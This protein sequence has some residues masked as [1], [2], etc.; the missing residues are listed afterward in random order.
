MATQPERDH[1]SAQMAVPPVQNSATLQ[2]QSIDLPEEVRALLLTMRAQAKSQ[3]AVASWVSRIRASDR[4]GRAPQATR[5]ALAEIVAITSAWLAGMLAAFRPTLLSGLARIQTDFGDTRLANYI[6]EHGYRWLI[7]APGH[8]RFWSP[9]VFFPAPNTA[10][11]S[12]VLFTVAPVYWFWRALGAAPDTAFQLWMLTMATLNVVAA[13]LLLRRALHCS[14]VASAVGAFVFAFAGVR[15]AQLQHPQLLPQFYTI[16]AVYALVRLFERHSDTSHAFG[17]LAVFSASIVAQLYAEFYYGW[18][19]CFVIAICALWA[20]LIPQSRAALLAL[21]RRQWLP[22]TLGVAAGA[23]LLAPLAMH[24]LSAA[25]VLGPRGFSTAAAMVPRPLSWID[26]GPDNW[27]YGP[28][29]NTSAM[30][31]IPAGPEQ[32]LGLG[33][34]TLCI[35]AWGLALAPSRRLGALLGLTA[36]TIVVIATRWTD[37]IILWRLV[38]ALVPGAA[39]L[40]AVARIG[41]LLLLPA[42]IG[43]AFWIDAQWSR[44]RWR[45]APVIAWLVLLV[46]AEQ[47]QARLP[48]FDKSDGRTRVARVASGV[49]RR[50]RSFFYTPLAGTEDPW[51][52]Q[53]DAM[54]ASMERDVPTVNGYS[55]NWPNGWR[56]YPIVAR[57]PA[58]SAILARNLARWIA[59]WHL[60]ARGVCTVALVPYD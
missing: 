59:Q 40:R 12:D 33:V 56:F 36:L 41:I 57:T 45:A 3:G 60:D 46:V 2:R 20:L 24:Y 11:Y 30:R 50:C 47:W 13:Y 54:W 19:L 38:F 14:A 28:L 52:Y 48:S 9:P 53:T 35:A 15:S 51:W 5:A 6:L 25:H 17:W 29:A 21:L 7:G 39:A 32:R 31:A 22:L 10:A 4:L 55:G 27:L 26:L 49:D 42:S 18:F 43:V 37:G 1:R 44:W 16:F 58:D 23:A 8:E 34:V